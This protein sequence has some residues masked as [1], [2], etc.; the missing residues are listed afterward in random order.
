VTTYRPRVIGLVDG[1]FGQSLSVWHKEILFALEN[2]VHVYGSSSMGAL[3]AAETSAFGMVGVG[4]VY[5]MYASGELEDD[6]EVAVAHAGREDGYRTLSVPMVNLRSTF[7]HACQVGICDLA[8]CETVLV[9]AKAIYYPERTIPRIVQAAVDAGVDADVA[10]NLRRIL[11]SDYVDVKRQDAILL[12]QTISH[13]PRELP[14]FAANFGLE[15]PHY[16][17]VLYERERTVEHSGTSVSLHAIADYAALRVADFDDLNFHA[18][19]RAV[20]V[21]MAEVLG[22]Q[23]SS[24][25]IAAEAVYFRTRRALEDEAVFQTWLA[26]NDLTLEEWSTLIREVAICRHVHGWLMLRQGTGNTRALLDELRLTGR[27]DEVAVAATEYEQIAQSLE[28]EDGFA[29][30]TEIDTEELIRDYLRH[31]GAALGR[32]LADWSGQAGFE[33]IAQLQLEL[34]RARLVDQRLA[35]AARA[36]MSMES[37][38]HERG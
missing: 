1:A 6:D 12:L 3:R 17:N 37:P 32:D 16:F 14:P 9:S 13:L 22:V 30:G 27:Y 4:E 11:Q 2:G 8:T 5:R 28:P 26:H 25:Q 19:N 7:T 33:S 31:T 23:I 21:E 10:A 38:P 18:L 29:S 36:V 34:L 24:E 35:R 20:V 15:R